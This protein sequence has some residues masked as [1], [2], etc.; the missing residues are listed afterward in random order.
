MQVE[1]Q[2]TEGD[3]RE[4]RYQ[5][6]LLDLESANSIINRQKEQLAA[7]K[8]EAARSLHDMSAMKVEM[9]EKEARLQELQ[10]AVTGMTSALQDEQ[11]TVVDL[12]STLKDERKAHEEKVLAMQRKT[13]GLE[14]MLEL[15]RQDASVAETDRQVLQRD[16]PRLKKEV[17]AI[18]DGFREKSI[19]YDAKIRIFEEQLRLSLEEAGRLGKLE[20]SLEDTAGREDQAQKQ[21]WRLEKEHAEL[22]GH[23]QR[24]QEAHD[25][26]VKDVSALR[27]E[28][29][30]E[31]AQRCELEQALSDGEK[32]RVELQ[33]DN[34]LMNLEVGRVWKDNE[35][36]NERVSA[37]EHK[38][39]ELNDAQLQ[40]SVLQAHLKASEDERRELE[41]QCVDLRSKEA[42]L[43]SVSGDLEK[44]SVT[45]WRLINA[46]SGYR[47]QHEGVGMCVRVEKN[48]VVI[49]S[50]DDNGAAASSELECGD[51]LLSV[52][53]C[54]VGGMSVERVQGL[55]LGP[56]GTEVG[57]TVRSRSDYSG[58]KHIALVRGFSK[59]GVVRRVVDEA[60]AAEYAAAAL[61][62]DL[63]E[64]KEL[65]DS[66]CKQ[67]RERYLAVATL[68]KTV[69]RLLEDSG[70]R[71]AG[72][73]FGREGLARVLS[74]VSSVSPSDK[75]GN[76]VP[77][78][79]GGQ[80]AGVNVTMG[81][82]GGDE[83]KEV[84]GDSMFL[85]VDPKVFERAL[86]EEQ[87]SCNSMVDA[88]LRAVQELL[89]EYQVHARNTSV[90][91][92]MESE[93]EKL[94]SVNQKLLLDLE[95]AHTEKA[96]MARKLDQCVLDVKQLTGEKSHMD[97]TNAD[98]SFTLKASAERLED[99][100]Q[101]RDNLTAELSQAK[102]SSRDLALKEE[103][104]L[105]KVQ[106]LE[107]KHAACAEELASA[108]GDL[109]RLIYAVTAPSLALA[110]VGLKV[111]CE[112]RTGVCSV[113]AVTLGG[114]ADCSGQV[115]V[116]DRLESVD[117]R[118][119]R[120]L[121]AEEILQLIG[122]RAGTRV[123]LVLH[124]NQNMSS[125]YEAELVRSVPGVQQ[126]EVPL[127]EQTLD[128]IRTAGLRAHLL[129]LPFRFVPSLISL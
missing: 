94:M 48:Q 53:G 112:D 36:L 47:R 16:M 60:V 8:G 117:G 71:T 84:P 42:A 18:V 52:N 88:L 128:A 9:E 28:L 114:S 125:L 45:A 2:K 63:I 50:L 25:L 3:S 100:Q 109:G 74:L 102:G 19:E 106:K 69:V 115:A 103:H 35:G 121:S 13:V 72:V 10:R 77:A 65:L 33:R 118:V 119:V 51:V 22:R 85:G 105:N 64:S 104:L 23:L 7:A 82:T 83:D 59:T 67:H 17:G 27:A 39:H 46:L 15:S 57:M 80:T 54:R 87:R 110:G 5:G 55:I 86:E 44:L 11:R 73:A 24:I 96:E 31:K 127:A 40:M 14:Q 6:V 37:V 99:L 30:E 41:Q 76:Q 58:S 68:V 26:A 111:K 108:S 79:D 61:Q 98:L 75:P 124:R 4:R 95:R 12:T 92:S 116:G 62:R 34:S 56:A 120:G 66:V 78:G 129:V 93:T 89:Q 43:A 38:E 91:R 29:K 107:A 126:R 101:L 1:R 122:G 123:N 113:T 32:Q 21:I 90:V 20:R 97:K 49:K 70:D 81:G